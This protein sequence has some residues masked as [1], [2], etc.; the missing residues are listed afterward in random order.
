VRPILPDASHHCKKN[1]LVGMV[2]IEL[3]ALTVRLVDTPH[4]PLW[5]PGRPASMKRRVATAEF[6]PAFQGRETVAKEKF[7]A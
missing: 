5:W 4:A 7:V 2:N 6:S 3:A 1:L